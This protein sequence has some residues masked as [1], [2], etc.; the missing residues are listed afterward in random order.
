[1]SRA[2]DILEAESENDEVRSWT[3][4]TCNTMVEGDG[5]HCRSCASYWEDVRNG[6]FDD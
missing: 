1:M 6:L 3:C 2:R 5:P 4:E